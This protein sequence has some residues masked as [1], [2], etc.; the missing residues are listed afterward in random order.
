MDSLYIEMQVMSS[1]MAEER[2][3]VLSLMIAQ[4]KLGQLIHQEYW[5]F[6]QA[7]EMAQ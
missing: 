5:V 7:Q 2:L 4:G 1:V 3:G 6:I